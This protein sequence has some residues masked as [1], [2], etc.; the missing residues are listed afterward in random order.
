MGLLVHNTRCPSCIYYTSFETVQ[1]PICSGRETLQANSENI[2][3]LGMKTLY[4]LKQD[5][6][7]CHHILQTLLGTVQFQVATAISC[8]NSP[9]PEV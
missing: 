9:L 7:S 1:G 2:S 5:S 4:K 3:I 8:E 6:C